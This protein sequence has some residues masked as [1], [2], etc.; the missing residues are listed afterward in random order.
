MQSWLPNMA[1]VIFVMC[2]GDDVTFSIL[3]RRPFS[4]VTE[5]IFST[6]VLLTS[7]CS[8]TSSRLS[9]PVIRLIPTR[10]YKPVR[11]SLINPGIFAIASLNAVWHNTT[12]LLPRVRYSFS[13]GCFSDTVLSALVSKVSPCLGGLRLFQSSRALS[14]TTVGTVICMYQTLR[15]AYV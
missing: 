11:M 12:L 4:I 5:L 9:V 7:P 14:L 3:Q 6:M 10:M 8:K 2:R 15:I 1:S 13:A